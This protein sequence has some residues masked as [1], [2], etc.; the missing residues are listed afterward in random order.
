VHYRFAIGT[1]G[2]AASGAWKLFSH[3]DDVYLSQRSASGNHKFS[4]HKSGICRWATVGPT[5]DGS[6]RA[7]IKWRRDAIESL[8]PG[9]GVLLL[10]LAFPT[11]HLSTKRLVSEYKGVEWI[12]PASPAK[13]LAIEIFFT[14]EKRDELATRFRENQSRRLHCC[15]QLECGHYVALTSREVDCGPVDFK[16]AGT[17]IKPG[18]VFGEMEFPDS[19]PKNTGRQIRLLVSVGNKVPPLFYE[20]G[21][22]ESI[23]LNNLIE[24]QRGTKP[25]FVP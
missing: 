20:L 14:V 24:I 17:P 3:K 25:N 12:P 4:F 15:F 23:S 18:Q 6:D 10:S 8:Q 13:A 19:D 2:G 7:M 11:N 9:N 5:L 21:G 1:A 16:I 22:Y